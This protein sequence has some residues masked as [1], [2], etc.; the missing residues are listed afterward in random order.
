MILYKFFNF[1]FECALDI[2]F[3]KRCIF[4]GKLIFAGKKLCVCSRCSY[5]V[6]L[7]RMVFGDD[8]TNC[9]EVLSPLKYEDGVRLSMLKFKFKSVKYYGY[10]YARAMADMLIGRSFYN[11]DCIITAVPIHRVRDRAYNQSEV[12]ARILC[13]LTNKKYC[14]NLIYKV[15]PIDRLSGMS[16]IDKAFYS[17]GSFHINS[18]Y[19]VSGKTVIIVDDIY[20]SGTTLKEL[21]S[22]LRMRGA[23]YV[24]GITA[25]YR[26]LQ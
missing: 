10:T 7:Q 17:K 9:D 6:I 11:D 12:I 24:Y 8:D 15:K 23:K 4:C 1:V 16:N 26:E 25:T 19:N 14:D 2:A 13:N 20:T 21:S 5:K 18:C 22:Q 3:P